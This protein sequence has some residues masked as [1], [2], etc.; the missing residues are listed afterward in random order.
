MGVAMAA[1]TTCIMAAL[2]DT[3]G[4]LG[5]LRIM[6]TPFISEESG[7]DTLAGAMGAWL[8]QRLGWAITARGAGLTATVSTPPLFIGTASW[9][10]AGC[11]HPMARTGSGFGS[12][13]ELGGSLELAAWPAQ[14]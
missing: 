12:V 2:S 6:A 3:I 9:S 10:G 13:S 8:S 11:A 4:I 14:A 7:T 5:I 1:F